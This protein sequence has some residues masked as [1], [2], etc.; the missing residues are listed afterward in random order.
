MF[1]KSGLHLHALDQVGST[2][3][4]LLKFTLNPVPLG[5]ICPAKV[6]Y[7]PSVFL[8][9]PVIV[10]RNGEVMQDVTWSAETA[11]QARPPLTA[12][13]L[14]QD[15]D[16]LISRFL[17][18]YRL[19]NPARRPQPTAPGQPD[20]SQPRVDD[21]PASSTPDTRGGVSLQGLAIDKV[22]LMVSAGRLTAPLTT[23]ALHQLTI[24]GLPLSIEPQGEDAASLSLEF[25]QRTIGEHCPGKVVYETGLF[26][27]EPVR[28]IRNQRIRIWSDTWVR[29][30]THVVPPV[31][32]QQLESDQEALVR[33]FI[34]AFQKK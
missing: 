30:R 7:A 17:E 4:A 15:L 34:Q 9:E 19:A 27:V 28:L 5:D 21:P 26:L 16:L 20:S 24:A 12:E 14:E 1:A 18:A 31:P 22:Q 3:I 29:E 6:L 2:P 25:I 8:I 32:V 10:P 13:E 11:P 23:R 33:E